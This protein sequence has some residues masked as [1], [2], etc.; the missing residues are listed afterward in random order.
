MKEVS[1][2]CENKCAHSESQCPNKA[3]MGEFVC[4]NPAQCWEPC[5]ALGKSEEHAIAVPRNAIEGT[6]E[7]TR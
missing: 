7:A 3:H 2:M 5:G 6:A 1:E 4:D